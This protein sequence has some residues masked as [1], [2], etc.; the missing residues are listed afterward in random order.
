MSKLLSLTAAQA[1][2]FYYPPSWKP[3]AGSL[4]KF[5]GSNGHLGHRASKLHLG[6]LVVRFEMPENAW[7]TGCSCHIGRGV[8]YNAEKKRVGQ[9]LSTPVYEF[10]TRCR[11]CSNEFVIRTDPKGRGYEF[12]EGIRQKKEEFLNE[13][14]G[15][16]VVDVGVARRRDG[17][18]LE[19]AVGS[20][21][22]KLDAA[23][24][25]DTRAGEAAEMVERLLEDT[26]RRRE[27]EPALRRSAR[28]VVKR[29]RREEE[30]EER[31]GRGRAGDASPRAKRAAAMSAVQSAVF[32]RSRA[33]AEVCEGPIAPQSMAGLLRGRA[34]R[35]AVLGSPAGLP[36]GVAAVSGYASSDS[37]G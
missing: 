3:E 35:G 2:G 32:V 27:A 19:A 13:Q 1:D 10:R 18:R 21:L 7:C 29:R 26:E 24:R 30:D 11:S 8:R 5:H 31:H 33:D 16:V 34:A 6:I 20:K 28:A 9:Y 36:E 17:T 4:D 14:D 12:A 23:S 25:T 37:D 22:E 15:T